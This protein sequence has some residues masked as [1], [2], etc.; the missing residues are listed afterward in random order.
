MATPMAELVQSRAMPVDRLEIGI[1]PRDLHKIVRG[2]VEGTVATDAEIRA[3]CRDQGLGLRQDHALRHGRRRGRELRR[4]FLALVGVEH[5]EALQEGNGSRLVPVALG[6]PALLIGDEAVGIDDSRAGLALTDMAAEPKRLAKREPA[7][8]RKAALYDCTP[9][10]QH[11]DPG[12]AAAG[13]GILR[14][15]EGCPRGRRAPGLDPGHAA[16]LQLGDDL[17]GDFLI[18]ARPVPAGASARG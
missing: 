13:R 9:Q 11:I 10:D 2:T 8:A 7:L 18:E 5:R 1:G 4:Q 14:H 6:P 16:C 12:V 3:R 17:V 15:G